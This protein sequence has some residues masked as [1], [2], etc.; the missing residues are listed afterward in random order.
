M[1]YQEG[2][3]IISHGPCSSGTFYIVNLYYERCGCYF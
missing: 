3:M 1:D 2:L